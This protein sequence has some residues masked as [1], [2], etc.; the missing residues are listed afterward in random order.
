MKDF[1]IKKMPQ[2]LTRGIFVKT[3]HLEQVFISRTP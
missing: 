1:T 3:S 2:A